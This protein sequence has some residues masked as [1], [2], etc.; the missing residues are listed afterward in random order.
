ML[1]LSYS[2]LVATPT[3]TSWS[4]VY[5]AG[6]LFASLS[7][8]KSDPEEDISLS[9]VGK[10]IFSNLQAEFFTLEQ[11]DLETI[12]E[13]IKNSTTSIPPEITANFCIAYF[14][15][16]ILYLFIFGKGKIV[17]KRNKKIAV[18]LEKISDDKE[19]L[20]ASGFLENDDTI[21]LQTPQFAQDM[22]EDTI[23]GALDLLIPNDIAEALSPAMHEKDDG[24]QAAIVINYKDPLKLAH[25]EPQTEQDDTDSNDNEVVSPP[26]TESESIIHIENEVDKITADNI[27]I[28]R[29]E[30]D[31]IINDHSEELQKPI[32]RPSS[33]SKLSTLFASLKL[34]FIKKKNSIRL[35]HRKK[36]FLSIA[37]IIAVVLLS[38]VLL[39]KQRESD[40]KNTLLFASVYEP[41]LADYN[42]G[43]DIKSINN[44]FARDDFLKAKNQLLEGKDKFKKGSKEEKQITEL[45]EK[46][47]AELGGESIG[48]AIKPKE[49]SLGVNDRLSV[50]KSNS[51]GRGF[52]KDQNG[53]YFVTDK[54]VVSVS[55][56]TKKDIIKNDDDWEKPVGLSTYQGNMYLL[57]QANGVLKF[58]AGS[59]GFGKS[60]YLK[61]PPSNISNSTDIAI[62]G[63]VWILFKD[64]T[65]MK[66]TRGES[67][68]YKTKGLN[69][70]FRNPSRLF[71]NIDTEHL[72]VLDTGNGQIVKLTKEGDFQK[73]YN[74]DILKTAKEF[75]VSEKDGKILV[76]SGGKFFEIPL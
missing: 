20:T 40:S 29:D 62:D 73:Q 30:V 63:A 47:E 43:I 34:P 13:A 71:T 52:T 48:P 18:L 37:V 10:D 26:L 45:L 72:Y 19:I 53:T 42:D 3:D 35:N 28:D 66:Y 23:S 14:K 59:N 61:K 46:I 6:N 2:K 74:A 25:E 67:D 5:N 16:N 32:L 9:S 70:P 21:L 17:M 60:S 31:I 51:T 41:A 38:S 33:G 55:G 12:K 54:A 64:G 75:E 49:I 15:E 7:L 39:T 27:T 76:L 36:L 68:E 4:Q 50:A 8:S 11:K 58:T 65:I 56:S 57:D 22:S 69:T 1:S 44:V 24:G